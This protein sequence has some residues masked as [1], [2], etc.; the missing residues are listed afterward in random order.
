MQMYVKYVLR[1]IITRSYW[2]ISIFSID[3]RK[4]LTK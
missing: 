3:L 4:V 1:C 2:E